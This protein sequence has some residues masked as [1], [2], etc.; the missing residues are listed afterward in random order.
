MQEKERKSALDFYTQNDLTLIPL[1]KWNAVI[2]KDGKTLSV[3]K[4][5]RDKN[6]RKKAYTNEDINQALSEGFNIGWRLSTEDLV[7]DVDPKNGGDKSLVDIERR[8]NIR[9][10][11][12]APTVVTG[13]GGRHFYFHKDPSIKIREV[14][15]D[16]NGQSYP[17]I[18]FKTGGRQVVIAASRHPNG[19]WYEFDDFAP[20]HRPLI[21]QHIFQLLVRPSRKDG[22]ASA[23]KFSNDEL[24]S[25]LE[26]L[27]PT[28]YRDQERWLMIMMA[29]HHAT[30][31]EGSDEFI[32]WS[33]SDPEY[34]DHDN[35]IRMRWDSLHTGRSGEITYKTLLD[36]IK[37]AGHM[38]GAE[39]DL[40]EDFA[41]DFIELPKLDDKAVKK[42]L[43]KLCSKVNLMDLIFEFDP[44][45]DT[46]EDLREIL[47]KLSSTEG[48]EKVRGMQM[49]QK[50]LQVSKSEINQL[51]K[52]AKEK[53]IDDLGE[54]AVR[55]ILE[56]FYANGKHLI[57][58]NDSQFWAYNGKYWQPVDTTAVGA[59]VVEA[60]Q[61]L[62]KKLGVPFPTNTLAR[63]TEYLI[64]RM[65]H[66][67]ISVLRLDQEPLPVINCQ[68]GE[69]WISENGYVELVPHKYDSYLTTCLDVSF[70]PEATAPKWSKA[71]REIFALAEDPDEMAEY[72][73]EVMGYV[74][75]P[76]KN[77][78]SWWLLNGRGSNGKSLLADILAALCGSAALAK[79][80]RELDVSKN[81]HAL[82]TL[83]GKLMVYDDD[84][85]TNIVLPDGILKKISERK[86][87]E[88]NPKGRRG[89][90]FIST[91]TPV[92]LTNRLPTIKDPSNGTKRRA[93]V[94]PFDRVFDEETGEVDINLGE[95]IKK[96]ELP[97]VLNLA[98]AGLLRLRERGRFGPPETVK[99]ATAT[100]L[101]RS[102]TF[103]AFIHDCTARTNDENDRVNRG[104]F[105]DAYLSWCVSSRVKFEVSRNSF[106]ENCRQIGL[107]EKPAGQR[108][109]D[110]VGVKIL[111]DFDNDFLE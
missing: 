105:Y 56:E 92:M 104:E 1:K 32:E 76:R 80:I 13:S 82:E 110:F 39:Y 46:K 83:P 30:D 90:S 15:E 72:F 3:G 91:A 69:L 37:K 34:A 111:E 103:L 61:D 41:D 84:M 79:P 53:T 9:F 29:S 63:E 10:E 12:I 16:E 38:I 66:A 57:Y 97:G 81:N 77:I 20:L 21:P 106:Y 75:Q 42:Q 58:V 50:K 55:Y 99:S 49:M 14:L 60:A 96:D 89:F 70:D 73:E 95:H 4:A 54:M 23:G 93:N 26:K 48:I 74:I 11:D 62:R 108:R 2:N 71:I 86:M 43:S 98:L 5:P 67:D 68:N 87:L 47:S 101:N 27:D 24:A 7:L 65:V 88:A 64:K 51:V 94:I 44:F 8:F 35:V 17:G 33:T 25:A 28:D 36:E 22:A 19:N 18:E 6:W 109:V 31:G 59:Q 40:S 52:D 85:D 100:F 45:K 78:A 107:K 102:N